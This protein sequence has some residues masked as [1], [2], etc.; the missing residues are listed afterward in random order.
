MEKAQVLKCI[1]PFIMKLIT[2]LI[3]LPIITLI[4]IGGNL[5]SQSVSD[6]NNNPE[7]KNERGMYSSVF[8]KEN[9]DKEAIYSASPVHYKK[10]TSGN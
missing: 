7:L 2:T 5:F 10:I 3:A 4:F 1:N 6:L 9:G 8:L